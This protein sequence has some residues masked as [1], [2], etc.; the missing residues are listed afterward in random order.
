MHSE[1]IIQSAYEIYATK[2]IIVTRLMGYLPLLTY[3]TQNSHPFQKI[4]YHYEGRFG[5]IK[6][7]Y[8]L[9]FVFFLLECLSQ[10]RKV[11][12]HVFVYMVHYLCLF[13]CFFFLIATVSVVFYVFHYIETAL[14][15]EI[16]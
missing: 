12:G 1:N 3:Y 15:K 10:E 4:S 16:N 2:G 7:V 13:L 5:R 14:M 11:S 9:R 8:P 6:L